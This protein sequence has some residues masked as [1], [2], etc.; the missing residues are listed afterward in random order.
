MENVLI[1]QCL[2]GVNCKYDGGN[3]YRDFVKEL[4]KKYNLIPFC[5]EILGGMPTPRVPSERKDD[6]V[7]N[8]KGIDVTENFIKGAEETLK[9][10]TLFNCKMAIVKSKSPS[11]GFG[12][13]YDGSFTGVLH[14]GNGYTVDLLLKNSIHI[15]TE[16]EIDKILKL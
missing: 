7:I 14:E 12:K 11:C 5:S 13:I 16:N 10:A 2:L 8:K 1:S 4:Q 3:N 15:Y 6:L 9:L